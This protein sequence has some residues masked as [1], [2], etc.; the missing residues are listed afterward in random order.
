MKPAWKHGQRFERSAEISVRAAADQVFP[1]LCP[2]REYEWIPDWR[3]TVVYSESGVAEKD[4]VFIT[5]QKFHRKAVWTLI[6]FEPPRLVEYLLV[7]GTDATT[8]LTISLAEQ[9]GVTRLTWRFLFTAISPLAR[10]VLPADFTEERFQRMLSAR[11]QQLRRY[12][13]KAGTGRA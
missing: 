13:A 12:F 6:T 9:D 5:L 4:A 2:V 10:R 1:L 11:E 3:C 8:R 7:M